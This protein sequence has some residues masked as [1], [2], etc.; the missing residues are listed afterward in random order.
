MTRN[1]NREATLM[2]ALPNRFDREAVTGAVGMR[3]AS[4]GRSRVVQLSHHILFSSC[5]DKA[6]LDVPHRTFPRPDCSQGRQAMI[7]RLAALLFTQHA[8]IQAQPIKLFWR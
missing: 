2:R 6:L 1:L 5:L 4:A 7:L 3:R 8:Q